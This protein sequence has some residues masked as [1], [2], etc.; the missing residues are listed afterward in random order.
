M[1]ETTC[2]VCGRTP[3]SKDEIALTKKLI[4]RSARSF[5]CLPCLS[6]SLEV[7]EEELL[8]KIRE[9][10]EKGCTLFQ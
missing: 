8:A 1:A 9:F 2:C 7:S 10:K 4:D 5:P 6:K 3:L